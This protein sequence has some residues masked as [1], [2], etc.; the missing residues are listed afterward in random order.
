ME[1]FSFWGQLAVQFVQYPDLLLFGSG[2]FYSCNALSYRLGVLGSVIPAMHCLTALGQW[3]VRIQQCTAL[4][5]RG[6]GQCNLCNTV[7]PPQCTACLP[8]AV[9]S[10]TLT[11]HCFTP[12]RPLAVELL[13]Y[14]ASL[15]WGSA[16]WNSCNALPYC[17]WAVGNGAPAI[18]CPTTW[19][20][21]AVDI[22]QH[23]A[24]PPRGAWAF[25]FLQYTAAYARWRLPP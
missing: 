10:A 24:S 11:M 5:P 2:Q 18:H 8:R 12:S 13:Q 25:D 19:G 17:L 20:Q 14:A 4:L 15:G 16:Q 7:Q 1:S 21:W 3:A 9:C 23:T 6:L 22:G